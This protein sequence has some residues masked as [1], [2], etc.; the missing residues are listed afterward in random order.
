M[1]PVAL[2][3]FFFVVGTFLLWLA[4][5]AATPK[6]VTFDQSLSVNRRLEVAPVAVCLCCCDRTSNTFKTY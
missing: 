2:S 4:N 1:T 5:R 6:G 3:L